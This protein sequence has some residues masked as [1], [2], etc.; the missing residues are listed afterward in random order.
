MPGFPEHGLPETVLNTFVLF[1]RIGACLMVMPGPSSPRVPVQVRLYLAISI[2][3]ALAPLLLAS[4]ASP[5]AMNSAGRTLAVAASETLIGASFGLVIRLFFLALQ[6]AGVLIAASIGFSGLTQPSIEESEASPA[7]G[8]VL[9]L[10]ATVLLFVTG[11]HLEVLAALIETYAFLP[12]G[13]PIER[14]LGLS[15]LADAM[16]EAFHLALR[17]ASPFVVYS[18][19]INLLLGI[20][21]RLVPQMAVYFISTPLV[22]FGGWNVF[23]GSI[24]DMLRLFGSVFSQ[25]L[26]RF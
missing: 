1:C 2:T 9:T 26:S 3:L 11:Q 10:T 23:H 4:M 17:I 18:I 6:F 5:V 24:D 25:W 20:M 15:R 12:V 14:E 13:E 7:L 19:L 22:I 16:V 8:T 21:N